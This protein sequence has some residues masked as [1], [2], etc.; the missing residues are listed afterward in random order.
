[1]VGVLLT[2]QTEVIAD[3]NHAGLHSLSQQGTSK[4][5]CN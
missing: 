5:F 1:M 2:K 3:L 4:M